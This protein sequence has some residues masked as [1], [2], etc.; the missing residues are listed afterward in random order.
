MLHTGS[1]A[2]IAPVYPANDD[3]TRRVMEETRAALTAGA[4]PAAALREARRLNDPAGRLAAF[5]FVS[6]G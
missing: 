6:F 2:V 5:S 4:S 3:A 1:G